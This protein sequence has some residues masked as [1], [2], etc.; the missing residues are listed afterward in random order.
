MIYNMLIA[1]SN[2]SLILF[3][4][5]D[6]NPG[7]YAPMIASLL[8][9]LAEKKPGITGVP[10]LRDYDIELLIAD[11]FMVVFALYSIIRAMK[12][13]RMKMVVIGLFGFSALFYSDKKLIYE[14]FGN[15]E[16][17]PPLHPLLYTISHSIWHL[18][19]FYIYGKC[20]D[21]NYKLLS[22]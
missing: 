11:R 22:H 8:Y 20:L 18:C 4:K 9:H 6:L 1:L 16:Y 7:W 21:Y 2:L 3:V 17:V 13:M 12:N 15:T 10:Y 19:A 14:F 5:E